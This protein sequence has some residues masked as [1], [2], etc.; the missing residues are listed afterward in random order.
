MALLSPPHLLDGARWRGKRVGLLGGSFNPPHAGHVHISLSALQSLELDCIWWLVTPQNP[1]K[2]IQPLPLRQRIELCENIAKHPQ[3][4]VSSLEKDLGTRKSVDTM[5]ALKSRFSQTEFIWIT[6]MDNAHEL[7]HWSK[8]KELLSMVPMAH[9]ARPPASTLAK[10]C[11]VR[12]LSQQKQIVTR[13]TGRQSL[14]S[15][16]TYWIMQKKMLAI[17]STNIRNK[18]KT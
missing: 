6:G 7:H 9:F 4:I 12:M 16:R 11:P 10:N 15:R 5:R 17:S 13:R 18:S 14:D 1:L 3:I 2:D 8:W